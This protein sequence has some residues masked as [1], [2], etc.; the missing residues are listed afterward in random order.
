L[1]VIYTL[2]RIQDKR[3]LILLHII[4]EQQQGWWED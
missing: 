4:S 1:L 2:L 3:C